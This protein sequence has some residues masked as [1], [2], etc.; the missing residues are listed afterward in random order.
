MLPI[1]FPISDG[2]VVAGLRAILSGWSP[3][4]VTGKLPATKVR[5]MVTVRNDSGPQ[6]GVQSRRR[7][8]VNVW[9]DSPVEAENIALDAMAGLR[10][11]PDGAPIT[12]TSNFTGPFE[13]DDE[14]PMSVGGK[15][16]THFYFTLQVS[17]RGSAA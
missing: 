9:A 1:R 16:L 13:I 11:L 12:R 17:V 10:I 4:S 2:I 5:R 3:I 6:D 7:Y 15:T 8:G 14:V